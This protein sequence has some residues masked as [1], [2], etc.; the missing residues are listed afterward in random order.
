M[1]LA[2]CTGA[3]L[4]ITTETE[5]SGIHLRLEGELAG[6][7][8]PRPRDLLAARRASLRRLLAAGLRGPRRLLTGGRRGAL[9]AR[10]PAS[11]RHPSHR[12][13][14]RHDRTRRVPR[15]GMVRSD[16]PGGTSARTWMRAT[17][18]KS[19]RA[20]PEFSA[21]CHRRRRRRQL[22]RLLRAA[23]R[24]LELLLFDGA[25]DAEPARVIRLEAPAHRTYHYWHAFVPGLRPGQV[26]AY[27]AAG[28][29]DPA[30]GLRFD[31]AKVLLDPYGRAVVV[32][33]AYDRAAASRPGDN[34][35][36]RH[37]ERG[38]GSRR[39]RLGRRRPAAPA[40]RQHG[41]LRDARRRLHAASKLGRRAA[42]GEARMPG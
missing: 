23:R 7:L 34:T 38:R 10:A 30:R 32:P 18:E 16:I 33:D 42:N 21:R 36:S 15:T 9:P 5:D 27:R 17:R 11:E 1:A 20:R 28:P 8:G 24:T 40:L 37:A 41:D 12:Q 31:P 3:M 19:D 2:L 35:A 39:L 22:L 25:A 14:R 4:K 29:F 13:Q 26:Y 6:E